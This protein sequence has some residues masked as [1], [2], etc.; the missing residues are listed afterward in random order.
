MKI[1]QQKIGNQ[2]QYQSASGYLRQTWHEKCG[3]Y[4]I[5]L[6]FTLFIETI[7]D[8][9]FNAIYGVKKLVSH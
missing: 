1:F 4:G 7:P 3:K 8:I 5:R 2:L 9:V 6:S